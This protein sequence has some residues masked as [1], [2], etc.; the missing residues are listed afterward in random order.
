MDGSLYRD[1]YTQLHVN[2]VRTHLR[3]VNSL[4][5]VLLNF[6]VVLLYRMFCQIWTEAF[7][8]GILFKKKLACI[9]SSN[10]HLS[11]M[12]PSLA[13]QLHS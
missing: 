13:W 6:H 3:K 10:D 8:A 9:H 5:V 4:D 7:A 12:T 1:E 11:A 2:T